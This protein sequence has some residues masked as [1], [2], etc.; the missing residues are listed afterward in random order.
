MKG[1]VVSHS[2]PDVGNKKLFANFYFLLLQ[3]AKAG[4]YGFAAFFTVLI[5]TQGITVLFGFMDNYVITIND[6]Y[7]SLLGFIMVF[8]IKLLENIKSSKRQRV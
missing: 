8:L 5:F 3:P 4:L 6:V 7:Y 1:T 2:H